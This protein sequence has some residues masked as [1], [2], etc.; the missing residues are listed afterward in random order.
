MFLR[1]QH[2]LN[3]L[4]KIIVLIKIL[5]IFYI[6]SRCFLNY[7]EYLKI[8]IF[9][10]VIFVIRIQPLVIIRIILII[11][12]LYAL[13][14]YYES[15]RFWF[16]YILIFIVLRG[17][18]VIFTY[19]IRLIPNESFEFFSF[20]VM[21]LSLFL[22][23]IRKSF[24]ILENQSLFRVLLWEGLIRGFILY[25]GILLLAIIIIVIFLRRVTDGALR[26]Y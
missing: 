10:G 17:V 11:V 7:K 13:D 18:I 26:I 5:I 16:G 15:I 9:L 2:I 21:G 8:S 24:I 3:T 20:L 1:H 12:L 25:L 14:I 19:V 23:F 4:N 22:L 6:Q